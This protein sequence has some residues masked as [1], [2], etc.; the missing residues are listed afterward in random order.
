MSLAITNT[1]PRISRLVAR[2]Q[3]QSSYWLAWVLLAMHMNVNTVDVGYRVK[4]CAFHH[5]RCYLNTLMLQ[6]MAGAER[7][8]HIFEWGRELMLYFQ[9]G[10]RD[11]K[12]W[13]PL[14]YNV[15]SPTMLHF[16]RSRWHLLHAFQFAWNVNSAI[17]SIMQSPRGP[18]IGK[19][20][21]Y[22]A[23]TQ[24]GEVPCVLCSPRQETLRQGWPTCLRLGSTRKVFANL[25]SN[26]R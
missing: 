24:W 14:V 2:L 4:W 16:V 11:E 8:C 20:C 12:G 17:T 15:N 10:P 6:L 18:V 1:S 9:M 5:V 21:S 7:L 22:L 13:E 19:F 23:C 25:R 26:G 3:A